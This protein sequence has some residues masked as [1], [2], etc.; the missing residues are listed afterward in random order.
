[1][2][3]FELARKL[4][5][6]FKNFFKDVFSIVSRKSGYFLPM[7]RHLFWQRNAS[8]LRL[9]QETKEFHVPPFM[10]FS[11]TKSCNLNCK[12][13]YS[14]HLHKTAEDDL[15]I[16]RVDSLIAEAEDLGISII[17]LAGGEPLLR[18]SILDVASKHRK[19]IFPLFT[20]GILIDDKVS[21]KLSKTKNILPVVSIEG[22]MDQTDNRRGEGV[23]HNV[24]ETLGKLNRHGVLFGT[25]ITVTRSNF[26][27]V[28]GEEFITDLASK[29]CSVVFYIEYIPCGENSENLTVTAEQRVRLRETLAADRHIKHKMIFISFPGD[30]ET[31]G[32]CLAAG[33]GFI[34]VSSCGNAEPCPFSPYSDINV[35]NNDLRSALN[36]AF[37]KNIRKNRDSLKEH[38]GGCALWENRQWVSRTLN[39]E[40]VLS[41]Q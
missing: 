17:L 26:D 2:E 3:G 11:V 15:S 8:K 5:I 18:E 29:G 20:N 4:D 39:G 23:Y 24:M 25:S 14:K 31:Y 30:E 35:K 16:E 13:C 12:G 32:G 41:R 6:D 40:K 9:R 22:S 10:I 1:M 7:A 19:V 33:R 36:S 27:N 28:T 21:E 37:L 38:N 34:H